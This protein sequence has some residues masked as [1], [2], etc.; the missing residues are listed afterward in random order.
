MDRRLRKRLKEQMA[1]RINTAKKTETN[2]FR[3][4]PP[5]DDGL[6]TL[7]PPEQFSFPFEPCQSFHAPLVR[8][9]RTWTSRYLRE[10]YWHRQGNHFQ[11]SALPSAGSNWIGEELQTRPLANYS[12]NFK[13][14]LHRRKRELIPMVSTPFSNVEPDW[15]LEQLVERKRREL[16][17]EED[18]LEQRLQSIRD[19]E[20]ELKL[21]QKSS[22]LQRLPL[23]KKRKTE[24]GNND[25][26]EDFAP[27]SSTHTSTDQVGPNG[28]P[29]SVQE[30]LDKLVQWSHTPTPAG[31]IRAGLPQSDV[32]LVIIISSSLKF[33]L[34][35][36]INHDKQIYFTSRTHSQL[37]QFIS[38]IR[39]T[40]FRDKVRVI[41][42]GSRANLCINRS[43]RDKS[44]TLEAINEACMDL[45]KSEKRCPHL[46]AMDEQDRMNDFRDHALAQ[47]HDIEELAELGKAQNCCPYYGSRKAVRRAQVR[48]REKKKIVTLPYNLVGYG[49]LTYHVLLWLTILMNGSFSKTHLAKLL[50]SPWKMIVDEAHN[51]IDS[52]LGI[53]TVSLSNNLMNQIHQAFE[54]YVNKFN[55]KLK[56]TKLIHLKHLIRVFQCLTHFSINW[57][58][59]IPPNKLRHEEIISTNTLLENSKVLDQLNVLELER[60]LHETE[61]KSQNPQ[62]GD[63]NFAQ[64]RSGLVTG[65]YKIEAFILAM[66]NAD[67][68]GRIL[69]VSE[70]STPSDEPTITIKYQLLDPSSSFSD[71]VTQARSVILAGGTMAPLDDFHS[72]LFPF[73]GPER[74]V[75]FSCSHASILPLNLQSRLHC[76]TGT[77][78][79]Q[80]CIYGAHGLKSSIQQDDLGQSVVNICNIVKDGVICFFPSY[81]SLDTLTERWKKTGL[82]ARLENKKKI[83][84][85]PKS[86]AEVDKILNGYASAVNQSTGPPPVSGG[87]LMLAVIGGKLSEGIN[88]EDHVQL[89]LSLSPDK[90]A[91]EDHP[92]V[93]NDLCRAVVVIGIPYPNAQSVELKER[94]KYVHNL[95]G[96]PKDAGKTFCRLFF[97]YLSFLIYMPTWPSGL[98]YVLVSNWVIDHSTLITTN[99]DN[100]LG[101]AIRHS[102]DWSAIILLDLRYGLKENKN[103]LPNWIKASM[104]S[105]QGFGSLIK[106][107]AQFYHQRKRAGLSS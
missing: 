37:N 27:D 14:N 62:Q 93:S 49:K 9:D 10:S 28:L 56:G 18:A 52:I 71:V 24:N 7:N 96:A 53:H 25:S 40:S 102:Q 90:F 91:A 72:Q 106:D 1:D 6:L 41:T 99:P 98:S 8:G 75:D 78:V 15:I 67:K 85:E 74:I 34:L 46:P 33:L 68:E 23:S 3:N 58:K 63:S 61:K 4:M 19:Q 45:Q 12:Q 59:N 36:N 16:L 77:S 47:I 79:G 95:A 20:A 60:Y 64:S 55:Q 26:D 81:A 48:R 38:E 29:K 51:L 82:W 17:A 11:L 100:L 97:F 86:T 13:L 21:K 69:M 94:I 31:R 73:V 30:M 101:R 35:F 22:N 65:F 2:K 84:I 104:K 80:G 103:R 43:V 44:K 5:S 54:S 92:V 107:L 105:S 89:R 50:V 32:L 39:K 87:G 83:F 42:L 70:R 76:S 57:S 66:S 88:C